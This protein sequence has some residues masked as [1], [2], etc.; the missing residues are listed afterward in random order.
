MLWSCLI[1]KCIW[2]IW[3]Q[4]VSQIRRICWICRIRWVH[5]IYQIYQ[6]QVYQ[7]HK[8]RWISRIR[9]IHVC[10]IS[11]IC[12][13]RFHGRWILNYYPK[14]RILKNLDFPKAVFHILLG[15]FFYTLFYIWINWCLCSRELRAFVRSLTV[16]RILF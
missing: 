16:I 15:P 12:W 13:I 2:K 11:W 5:K 4:R 3:F 7:I 10:R 9:R 8:I 14:W 6:I 1:Y